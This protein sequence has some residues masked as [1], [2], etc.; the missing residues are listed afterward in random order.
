ADVAGSEPAVGGERLCAVA[1]PPAGERR[2]LDLALVL[3]RHGLEIAADDAQPRAGQG[4]ARA[5]DAEFAPRRVGGDD[6]GLAA[7]VALARQVAAA[8]AEGA[9]RVRRKMGGG[10]DAQAQL[11]ERFAGPGGFVQQILI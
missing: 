7:A 9:R 6:A 8:L 1:A 2:K 5:V 10:R 4:P 3:Q 11:R